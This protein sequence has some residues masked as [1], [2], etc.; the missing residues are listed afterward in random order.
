MYNLQV[1]YETTQKDNE[2]TLLN[3]NKIINEKEII[4]KNNIIYF[5][6]FSILL[7]VLISF[8]VFRSYRNSKKM[9]AIITESKKEIE[10]KNKDITDS[11]NYAKRI[12]KGMLSKYNAIKSDINESF[13]LFEPK[14]IVSGDFY[15]VEEHK[16]KTL[17]SISDCTGHG[18]PGA[19]MSFIG[20]NGLNKIVNEYNVTKP[21]EILDNLNTIVADNFSYSEEKVRDGMD[22]T[23]CS[24]NNRSRVL[25]FAGANNPMYIVRESSKGILDG[26]TV[27]MTI[28]GIDLYKITGDKAYIGGAT[29]EF[30]NRELQLEGGDTLYLF[31][32]GYADQ[33]GGIKGKKFMYKRLQ[34]LLIN[35]FKD[36][37][38]NQK[39]KL[40]E[41]LAD[42]IE[43][44]EQIDDITIMGFK[45]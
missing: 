6:T 36:T 19:F 40:E 25:E 37:L 41:A 16:D 35:N 12:Q 43:G 39:L 27:T 28:N 32:D 21:S 22:M 3:K 7:F 9:N 23:V 30:T 4:N 14:D 34:K 38:E 11:I 18:V 5:T 15:W 24:F 20:H 17:F 44:H 10:N 33:F 8:I 29:K 45:A 1:K 13:M 31:T 26:Q 2:I 42:W